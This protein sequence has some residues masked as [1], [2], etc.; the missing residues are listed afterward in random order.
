MSVVLICGLDAIEPYGFCDIRT[1]MGVALHASRTKQH[2]V[3]VRLSF[4][5]T[6]CRSGLNTA[7]KNYG[8]CFLLISR[9]QS[10][11]ESNNPVPPLS[12]AAVS[13]MAHSVLY[14]LHER[15]STCRPKQNLEGV[16]IAQHDQRDSLYNQNIRSKNMYFELEKVS[17]E[18]V[19]FLAGDV[20]NRS[21]TM[22]P[23]KCH[24]SP[25][26]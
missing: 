3:Q 12:S 25:R 6:S 24:P 18:P 1:A 13:V 22:E 21:D 2:G 20:L 7:L 4:R 8:I 26:N 17:Y 23:E 14:C 11:G 16:I 5:A 10:G 9:H 19:L 15:S